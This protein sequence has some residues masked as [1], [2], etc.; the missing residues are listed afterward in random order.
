MAIQSLN[1][2]I[3]EMRDRAIR[4]VLGQQASYNSLSAAE[5]ADVDAATRE[6]NNR[7]QSFAKYYAEIDDPNALPDELQ[8][9]L[10]AEV[11]VK[12]A[13]ALRGSEGYEL[14]VRQAE[15]AYE[16]AIF[17]YTTLWVADPVIDSYTSTQFVRLAIMRD[18][19]RL[20]D[21]V[22]LNVYELDRLARN[23]WDFIWNYKDWNFRKRD[24]ELTLETNGDVTFDPAINMDS[25]AMQWF[26]YT[27]TDQRLFYANAERFYRYKARGGDAGRPILFRLLPDDTGG[28][29]M[30]LSSPPDK[31]YTLFGEVYIQTPEYNDAN[32][33]MLPPELRQYV[34]RWAVAE[35]ASIYG[36]SPVSREIRGNTLKEIDTIAAQF[37]RHGDLDLEQ[38]MDDVY[39]DENYLAG[40]GGN[41]LGGRY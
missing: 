3:N 40:G 25:P 17:S 24:V 36:R 30:K 18:L 2:S 21:R 1:Y 26:V 13:R 5:R 38:E 23:A 19:V 6:G 12:V 8:G 14:F 22:M 34:V 20:P 32:L 4:E 11:L 7:A 37:D 35:A 39:N 33:L 27:D 10:F 15:Q 41:Q 9:V 28:K 16:R 29:V 31:Q